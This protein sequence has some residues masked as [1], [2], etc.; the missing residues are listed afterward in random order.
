MTPLRAAVVLAA[1]LSAAVMGVTVARAGGYAVRPLLAPPRGSA[2][3]GVRYAFGMGLSPWAKAGVREHLW[4]SLAPRC[5][6]DP[7]D[8]WHRRRN[9][10]ARATLALVG[11]SRNQRPG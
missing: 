8:G 2:R 9:D 11:T 4:V 5:R 6:P 7:V 1:L 10:S 3:R